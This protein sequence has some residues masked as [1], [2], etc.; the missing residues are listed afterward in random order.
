MER[1]FFMP[2][3]LLYVRYTDTSQHDQPARITCA[4]LGPTRLTPQ[5]LLLSDPA[6]AQLA[7]R[8]VP[9]SAATA[10]NNAHPNRAAHT[11]RHPPHTPPLLPQR[12]TTRAANETISQAAPLH[13]VHASTTTRRTHPDQCLPLAHPT[14]SGTKMSKLPA[15]QKLA[16][17]HTT[18]TRHER[19]T[20]TTIHANGLPYAIQ[21]PLP[22]CHPSRKQTHRPTA[23]PKIQVVYPS[24]N[25]P[26]DCYSLPPTGT[27]HAHHTT[28]QPAH[29]MY[30]FTTATTR[31]QS[32]SPPT[33]L[34]ERPHNHPKNSPRPVPNHR[35]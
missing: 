22:H 2:S 28:Q 23:T 19:T 4:R 24:T 20:R 18:T 15:D 7:M 10:T 32:T 8:T 6:I 26:A 1:C 9:P 14:L 31:P 27:G 3:P 35:A 25:Q 17:C 11:R 33:T 5:S 34:H 21:R 12:A 29:H 30:P 13:H 16:H